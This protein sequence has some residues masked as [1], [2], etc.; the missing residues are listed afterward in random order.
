MKAFLICQMPFSLFNKMTMPFQLHIIV[1]DFHLLSHCVSRLVLSSVV[2]C[3]SVL[4]DLPGYCLTECDV[5]IVIN[6][7]CPHICFHVIAS[8]A[9]G[10]KVMLPL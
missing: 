3:F 4:R 10:M 8:S 2:S 1:T 6:A 7:I 5:S 9:F